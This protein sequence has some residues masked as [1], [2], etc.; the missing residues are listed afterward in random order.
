[1]AGKVVGIGEMVGSGVGASH[2]SSSVVEH[3]RAEALHAVAPQHAKG[4][5]AVQAEHNEVSLRSA[6]PA[7]L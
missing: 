6:G 5:G 7:Q 3:V 1:M 2:F 4:V